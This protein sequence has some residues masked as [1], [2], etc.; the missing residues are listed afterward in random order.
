MF[1][2]VRLLMEETG[3]EQGEAEL[4]LELA[5]NDLEK[6]IKTIGS[7][8]RHIVALKGKLN[9]YEKS[10]YGLLLIVINTKSQEIL[11]LHTVVTYNPGLYENSPEMDWYAL[12]K[13]IF[14]YRL[15]AGSL[16]DFTQELEQKLTPYLLG[17]KDTL[18]KCDPAEI[19]ALLLEFLA[20]D[21]VNIS[22]FAEEL[23]LTEFRRLPSNETVN[24]RS[25]IHDTEPGTVWLEVDLLEDADGKE[26]NKLAEGETVLSRITD[27]RD[28]AHYLAHLIGGQKESE[29]IPLPAVIKK[30]AFGDN[31]SEVQ[32]HYAPGIIGI[33]KVKNDVKIKLL[34]PKE[35]SWWKK[36]IPWT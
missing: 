7:L 27:T 34:E 35:E 18:V 24:E 22:L 28:I 4:A 10:L 5:D 12:E 25:K 9:F 36:I 29:K 26:L 21:K 20:P 1:E 33:A 13:M 31:E 3:C 16:P 2:K 32:V 6:A 11:R 23:N 19:K 30:I 15:D 14:S 17:K 8:L